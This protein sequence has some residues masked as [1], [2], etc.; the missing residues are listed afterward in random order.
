MQRIREAHTSKKTN[1][2]E[3]SKLTK[4]EGGSGA[5]M[6]TLSRELKELREEYRRETQALREVIEA[7]KQEMDGEKSL[8][9]EKE[10]DNG[11]EIRSLKERV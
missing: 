7:L 1:N 4:R 9:E 11:Q 3:T 5:E 6:E 10:Q 2:S 8:R